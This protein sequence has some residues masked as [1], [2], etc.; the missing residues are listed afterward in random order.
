MIPVPRKSVLKRK[1]SGHSPWGAVS[2]GSPEEP[3]AGSA[4]GPAD[5]GDPGS[6][7]KSFL[8]TA[9]QEEWAWKWKWFVL[10]LTLIDFVGSR[11][12]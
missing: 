10:H 11:F 7:S 8:L 2:L 9:G 12:L 3:C 5:M 1:R 4:P 6:A